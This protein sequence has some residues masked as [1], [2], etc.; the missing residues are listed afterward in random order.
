MKIPKK[1]KLHGQTIKVEYD[2]KLIQKEDNVGHACFRENKIRLQP[3]ENNF[4]RPR[5]KIEETFLHELVHFILNAMSENELRDNEKFIELFSGL[6]HQYIV[7]SEGKLKN[8]QEKEKTI[9]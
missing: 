7:T 5:A 2:K 3:D 1:F 9:R 4:I 8:G 6:L